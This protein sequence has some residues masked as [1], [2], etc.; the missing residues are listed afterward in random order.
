MATALMNA[1]ITRGLVYRIHLLTRLPH[2][3]NKQIK[4]VTP[5]AW[6]KAK[7]NLRLLKAAS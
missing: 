5:S 2:M 7:K 6:A 3:T 4:D 1:K